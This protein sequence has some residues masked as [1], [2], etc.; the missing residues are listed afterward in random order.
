MN[1]VL[2]TLQKELTELLDNMTIDEHI[3]SANGW[4]HNQHFKIYKKEWMNDDNLFEFHY[5]IQ[6]NKVRPEIFY[7]RIDCHF[8][9]YCESA[10][11]NR[12]QYI[13]QYGENNV[14]KRIA[15]M[16]DVDNNIKIND[17]RVYRQRWSYNS[18]WCSKWDLSTIELPHADFV[19]NIIE[20]TFEIVD[21]TYKK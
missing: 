12:E 8:H 4:E 16:K 18:V 14:Y 1:Y 11:L 7:L 3:T 10:N 21:R 6:Q 20:N 2:D 19:K 15:L 17:A 13:E 5:E 9:P